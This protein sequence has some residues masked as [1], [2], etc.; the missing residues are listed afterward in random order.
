MWRAH[1]HQAAD[2]AVGRDVAHLGEA[3]W[4]QEALAFHL[5][6]AHT[7]RG[8]RRVWETHRKAHDHEV[9]CKVRTRSSC[10]RG[11]FLSRGRYELEEQIFE[12]AFV[13]G[14]AEL[15]CDPQ[16]VN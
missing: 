8:R 16:I 6:V 13:H 11:S 7:Q 14:D 2:V 4:T 3:A 5:R 15:P 10:A 1:D 12:V 9:R